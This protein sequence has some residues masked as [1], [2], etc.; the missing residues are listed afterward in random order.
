[1]V[2]LLAFTMIFITVSVYTL[3]KQSIISPSFLFMVP[4]SFSAFWLILNISRWSVRL[5]FNTYLVI[6]GGS[7]SFLA[8]VFIASSNRKI[9][10]RRF[11]GILKL[12]RDPF[13][14]MIPTILFLGILVIETVVLI[15]SLLKIRSIVH[16]N[17]YRGTLSAEI[18]WFRNLGMYTTTSTSLGQALDWA[19][20]FNMSAGYILIYILMHRIT[21]K[22][23]V[24]ISIVL[25][26]I[27]TF[28]T[29]LIRGGR[30]ST[31]QIIIAGLCYYLLFILSAK[32]RQSLPWK[33]II[34]ALG[35]VAIIAVSF[36]T[37]G[38][39]LGRTVQADFMQYLAVYISGSIRNLNEWLKSPHSLPGIFGKMTFASI[40]PYLGRKFGRQDWIYVLD[41]PYLT[42]NNRNS[43]NIY[44][45]FYAYIYDFGYVGAVILPFIMGFISEL[46]YKRAMKARIRSE[47]NVNIWIILYGYISYLLAFSFFSNKFYE[48]LIKHSFIKYFFLWCVMSY[49]INRLQRPS[50]Y[51]LNVK[52]KPS[53]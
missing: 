49:F 42:A 51:A 34:T 20:Q 16:Q 19:Y 24:N 21:R 18:F 5:N 52:E 36:Q 41:L 2:Y 22:Q 40:Y 31:V 14:S 30:Q 7:L 25:C 4:F 17:N 26:L 28:A 13:D 11:T 23:K 38:K 8:G 37:V 10:M 32:G 43:G 45:T 6:V 35:L 29:G 46:V 27:V 47:Y 15:L 48:G 3:G 50:V 39:I 9:K 1:M 53:S 44:T 12:K 33:A